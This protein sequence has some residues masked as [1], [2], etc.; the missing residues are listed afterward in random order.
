MVLVAVNDFEGETPSHDGRPGL[1]EVKIKPSAITALEFQGDLTWV[2]EP[3]A[4][5]EWRL[6][7][8]NTAG[9]LPAVRAHIPI[10]RPGS[11][12]TANL[13]SVGVQESKGRT[14]E[15]SGKLTHCPPPSAS[16]LHHAD[17]GN[18]I[19]GLCLIA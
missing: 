2:R 12:L 3:A 9:A 14:P 19:P 8:A 10:A 13:A 11:P 7:E 1:G 16:S 6:D 5:A 17:T 18:A 4:V 15:G